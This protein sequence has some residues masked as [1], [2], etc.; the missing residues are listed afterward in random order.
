M[1]DRRRFAQS[2]SGD[3]RRTPRGVRPEC[4][5]RRRQASQA[6]IRDKRLEICSCCR[7]RDPRQKCADR[8]R[9]Q[10]IEE[11]RPSS[12]GSSAIVLRASNAVRLACGADA[13]IIVTNPKFHR[14]AIR[15]IIGLDSKPSRQNAASGREAP[16]SPAIIRTRARRNAHR[17]GR[18]E[19]A[20]D[21]VARHRRRRRVLRASN[22]RSPVTLNSPLSLPARAYFDAASRLRANR[23]MVIPSANRVSS[24]SCS[25]G[26]HERKS[27]GVPRRSRERLQILLAHER[28]AAVSPIFSAFFARRFWPSK[29]A[30]LLRSDKVRI[31]MDRV[32]RSRRLRSISIPNGQRLSVVPGGA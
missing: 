24:T 20:F 2:R 26:K 14:C 12:T 25:D 5:Q 30:R 27:S 28:S 13:A 23:L 18:L 22:L 29:A 17:S 9:R 3:G 19:I 31:E 6:L 10:V 15:R 11:R 8:R 1:I 21:T 4:H 16:L 32:S 7:H